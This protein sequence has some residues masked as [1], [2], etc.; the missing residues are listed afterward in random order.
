MAERVLI[1]GG[2]GFIGRHLQLK[3]KEAGI[4]FFVYDLAVD[5]KF[6]VRYR[7]QLDQQVEQF[8]ATCIV[9][10]SGVLGTNELLQRDAAEQAIDVNIKGALSVGTVAL[11]NSCRLVSIEQPHIWY[12]VYEASKLAARRMLTGM[13]LDRGLEVAFITAHN[14]FGEGQAF[15]PGHPQKIVPTFAKSA[16]TGGSL[17]IWGDG[18]QQCNLVYAGQVAQVLYEA[19]MHPENYCDPLYEYNA[20][21]NQLWTVKQL[22]EYVLQHVQ[23]AGLE[24]FAGH[25]AYQPMRHGEQAAAKYPTPDPRWPS[26]DLDDLDRT[27]DWYR[28]A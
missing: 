8:K 9:H 5:P 10:L 27:I 22:A 20:A 19:V 26:L 12:N 21:T 17:P 4:P 23:S 15:G 25:I 1:T 6:D 24:V 7:A 16:W 2:A 28:N 3:L 11:A 14:A 18:S 13:A